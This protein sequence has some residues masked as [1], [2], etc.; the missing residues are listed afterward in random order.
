MHYLLF[1]KHVTFSSDQNLSRHGSIFGS[2][3]SARLF[4]LSMGLI[5]EVIMKCANFIDFSKQTCM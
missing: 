4:A 1:T 3:M 5:T 2:K